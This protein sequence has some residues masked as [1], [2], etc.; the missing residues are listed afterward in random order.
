[1][2]GLLSGNSV[3]R[4]GTCFARAAWRTST[5][6]A[7]ICRGS[8]TRLCYQ[9]REFIDCSKGV[10]A[11]LDAAWTG[12]Q[13][14]RDGL[15]RVN[16]L[17]RRA[18]FDFT[19]I[20][21]VQATDED[22]ERFAVQAGNDADPLRRPLFASM[23]CV[24]NPACGLSENTLRV[25]ES[26][27]GSVERPDEKVEDDG[28]QTSAAGLARSRSAPGRLADFEGHIDERAIS[29]HAGDD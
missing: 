7:P 3:I 15:L 27:F 20:E 18:L 8:S 14:L 16:W 4:P 10:V 17:A 2:P 9:S 26:V 28:V 5:L 13:D 19:A 12:A 1:M 21:I 22:V 23:R 11:V 6:T 24:V 25:L 29:G